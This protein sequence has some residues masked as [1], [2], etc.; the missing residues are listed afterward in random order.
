MNEAPLLHLNPKKVFED[1]KGVLFIGGEEIK[2]DLRDILREQ[3]K[4]METSQLFEMLIATIENEAADM[5]LNKSLVWNH[6]LSA[7]MLK[8]WGDVFKKMVNTLKQ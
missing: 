5:A 1:R 2:P 4:Y 3:A 7:K 6:V 8:Y